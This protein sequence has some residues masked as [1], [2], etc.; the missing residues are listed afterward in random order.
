MKVGRR[1][2][3]PPLA[4]FLSL[5]T[6][7]ALSGGCESKDQASAA[8]PMMMGRG[9]A[10]MAAEA[11]PAPVARD[12][13][14]IRQAWLRVTVDEVAPAVAA[15]EDI[16]GRAGGYVENRRTEQE[17]LARIEFRVPENSLDAVLD[18]VAALG[19]EEERS[20]TA[21]DVT[22]QLIDL[23]AALKNNLSLRDR[24]RELLERG[25]KV[26]DLLKIETELARVQTEID[27]LEGQLKRIR[28]QVSL[29]TVTVELE[30]R[31]VLGPLGY[32]GQGLAWFFEKAFVIRD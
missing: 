2:P 30:R 11:P 15:V 5:V 9:A 24:L 8:P 26:E 20:V 13:S 1:R 23:D 14:V 17:T 16:V 28:S 19:D 21:T 4:A 29:S 22:E 27:R 32:V 3:G 31:R 25:T 10:M 12:R 18:S 6:I 7:A